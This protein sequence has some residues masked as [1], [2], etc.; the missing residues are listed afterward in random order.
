M[1]DF[2]TDKRKTEELFDQWTGRAVIT[3][4]TRQFRENAKYS[5]TGKQLKT[6]I[7]NNVQTLFEGVGDSVDYQESLVFEINYQ[8][9]DIL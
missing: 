3:P 5:N 1:L 2:Q 8:F 4:V 6:L 7:E 9:P